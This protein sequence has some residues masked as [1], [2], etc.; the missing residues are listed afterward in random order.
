M[1][2]ITPILNLL[3]PEKRKNIFRKRKRS[4]R[5]RNKRSRSSSSRSRN[6]EVVIEIEVESEE[7]Q[8]LISWKNQLSILLNI[9]AN[10][11]ETWVNWF[12]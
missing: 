6:I 11:C 7:A 1:K 3:D 8:Q 5:A 12:S 10:S 9:F 2:R 4:I